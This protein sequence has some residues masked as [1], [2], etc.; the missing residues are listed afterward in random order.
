LLDPFKMRKLREL[1][2][3]EFT[4]S[5]FNML[6]HF[7]TYFT[8]KLGSNWHI[9]STD[10]LK[11]NLLPSDIELANMG[12]EPLRLLVEKVTFDELLFNSLVIKQRKEML[13]TL[14]RSIL[15]YLYQKLQEE[16][17]KRKLLE[18]QRR[19]RRKIKEKNLREFLYK[20][21]GVALWMRDLSEELCA[22]VSNGKDEMI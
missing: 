4:L 15:D 22:L 21:T 16:L 18:E 8:W 13:D 9:F 5:N 20:L 12:I 6:R 17:Q 3:N 1:R 10:I 2:L 7:D 14:K 11:P 19:K